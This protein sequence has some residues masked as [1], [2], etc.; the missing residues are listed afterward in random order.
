MRVKIYSVAIKN[1]NGRVVGSIS[2]WFR[3]KKGD[4]NG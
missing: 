2:S 3:Y 4:R 1:T